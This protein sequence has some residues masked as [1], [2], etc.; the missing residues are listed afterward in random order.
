MAV[1]S[2][3][4][5]IKKF[6]S[7]SRITLERFI[8]ERYLPFVMQNKRSW[9]TDERYTTHHVLPYLGSLELRQIDAVVLYSW[10][11]QLLAKCLS[12]NTCY[13]LFWLVKYILNCAV[14]WQVLESNAAF[15]ET[16]CPREVLRLTSEKTKKLPALLN[17]YFSN[18]SAHDVH[19]LFLMGA[20]KSEALYARWSDVKLRQRVLVTR[21]TPSGEKRCIPAS[22]DAVSLIRT[23]PRRYDVSW[24]FFRAGSGKRVVFLFSF[25]DK[26]RKELGRPGLRLNDLRHVF[27]RALMQKGASYENVCSCL[28]HYSAE[29]FHLQSQMQ[30][31]RS[32]FV[33]GGHCESMCL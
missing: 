13:R 24:V 33:H 1:D 11:E 17:R 3:Q 6:F 8:R 15:R 19:L 7:D 32:D 21:R 26:L 27:A 10:C 23:F 9:Q 29:I 28:G 18:V 16:T 14:R 5:N 2:Q 31:G 12:S 25:W 4:R 20:S 30:S 22:S